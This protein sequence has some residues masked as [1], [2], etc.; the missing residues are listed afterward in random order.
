MPDKIYKE[1]MLGFTLEQ[2]NH[3]LR[4][5]D[6]VRHKF[7]ESKGQIEFAMDMMEKTEQKGM[8]FNKQTGEMMGG[9]EASS[10]LVDELEWINSELD[11]LSAECTKLEVAKMCFTGEIT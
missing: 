3:L 10:A 4:N 1:V 6:A 7:E 9:L 11:L 5:L 8:V 2:V